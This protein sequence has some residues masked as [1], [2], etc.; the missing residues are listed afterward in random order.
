MN[1]LKWF[2]RHRFADESS[3]EETLGIRG[4]GATSQAT[5]GQP[6]DLQDLIFAVKREPVAHRTVFQVAHDIFDKWFKVEDIAEKPDPDI[7]KLVQK[8][9]SD[10]NAKSVSRGWL[11]LSVLL[12]G[13]S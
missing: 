1:P 6:V 10:L 9:L 8:A 5:F 4:A 13:Q 7:D 11:C 12:V 2:L 3:R